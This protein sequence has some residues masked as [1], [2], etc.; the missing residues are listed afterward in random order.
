MS[1]PRRYLPASIDWGDFICY[2]II[3]G[4]IM[5]TVGHLLVSIGEG[6]LP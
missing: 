2:A 4:A 1:R 5:F 6:R 3:A